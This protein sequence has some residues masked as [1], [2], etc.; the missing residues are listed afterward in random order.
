MDFIV[1]F[2]FII[3]KFYLFFFPFPTLTRRCEPPL[4]YVY[5][6]PR[7]SL[8]WLAHANT[9]TVANGY[10]STVMK[11]SWYTA[12][13]NIICRKH[14]HT[15]TDNHHKRRQK[16]RYF[17]WSQQA[18]F[19]HSSHI[20]AALA[21]RTQQ[22]NG[23]EGKSNILL[24]YV[25]SAKTLLTLFRPDIQTNSRTLTVTTFLSQLHL[26]TYR[27]QLSYLVRNFRHVSYAV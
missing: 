6:L 3:L 12:N 9:N 24:R 2:N 14:I 1:I 16:W 20:S 22:Q 5:C 23:R 8:P 11:T 15:S 19:D 21:V 18:F 17:T 27:Y 10:H 4:M 26:I 13:Y 7:H 25:L